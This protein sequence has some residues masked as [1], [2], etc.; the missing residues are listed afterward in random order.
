MGGPSDTLPTLERRLTAAIATLEEANDRARAR[1]QWLARGATL[2]FPEQRLESIQSLRG[3]GD[4]LID[5]QGAVIRGDTAT[6][7]RI[8]R[9]VRKADAAFAPSDLTLDALYPEASLLS[10]L[11]R[12]SAAVA[13]LDPT[14]DALSTTA[15]GVFADPARAGA[16]VRAMI[17]RA[18]LAERHGDIRTATRWAR[19]VT[20]LWIH[21]DKFLAPV[22]RRME[23]LQS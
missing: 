21:A 4:F 15:P 16:L 19:V 2:A 7:L 17:F 18:S 22:V 13:W 9:D 10:E 1:L 12:D 14:L 8:L 6:A 11:G 3:R 5:A 20:L 23:K